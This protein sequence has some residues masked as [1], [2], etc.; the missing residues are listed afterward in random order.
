MDAGSLGHDEAGGLQTQLVSSHWYR[1]AG[2]APR[3]RQQ[4]RIHAQ[5]YRGQLW[6][7]IEDRVNGRYHRFERRAWRIIR[8]LDG[9]LTLERLWQRLATEG[10]P[11]APSQEDVLALLGQLHA[12]DLLA[13]GSLPDLAEAARRQRRLARMRWW[14]RYLNPLALRISLVDPDR[15]LR[16]AVGTLKPILNGFGAALWLAWVAPAVVLAISHWP[17]LTS[18]FTERMLAFGNLALLWLIFPLVKALHEIGHG[19]ACKM[20][21]GEVHDMGVMMLI[22]LPV[23]YVD[24]SSAWTFGAKRDRV[25]VGAAGMLV[26]LCI[27]AG[28]FYAWLWLEPGTARAIA[29]D[30]AVLASVTTVVFN[31]NPLLR[32]DGYYIASDVLEIPN[33]GQRAARYWGYLV[34][35][36]ILRH[37]EPSSPVMARGEA[38]WFALYAPLSLGYRLLVLFSIGLFVSTKYFAFGVLIAL[39]SIGAALGVPLY[40]GLRG[41]HRMLAEEQT[42]A[43]G[44][45][46]LLG[47]FCAIAAFLFVVPLRHSTQVQGVVWLPESGVVRAEN[48]GFIRRVHL[49][50]GTR[51]PSGADILSLDDPALAAHVA[52]QT[53]RVDEAQARYDAGTVADPALGEQLASELRWQQAQ[54]RALEERAARL[55]VRSAGAGR[56]WIQDSEDLPGRY[57]KEGEVV[58]YVIPHAAPRIRVIVGQADADFIRAHTLGIGVKLPFDP[59]TTW[60]AR[61]VR[62]VPEASNELPSAALGREGGGT[63]ATD[64]RDET[65]RKA[66]TSHFEYELA[67]PQ[68]FPYRL[69]GSRASVRFE[70]PPEPIGYRIWRGLRR[71]FLAYFRS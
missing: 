43:G 36:W 59:G 16:R 35:R 45:L 58:G 28:A 37:R 31:A 32:Y 48:S 1:A 39:W 47:A 42:G 69:I 24:A 21:G 3:L 23:P 54:L 44:K 65:G 34:E 20:R 4:L 71:L 12:L 18:N 19:V 51:V 49:Q 15:F 29:Y 55:E 53:A 38:V 40:R 6:F 63:V 7:V 25:L 70:H 56:L 41:L 61:I 33:L 5:R 60:S 57:V 50:N 10:G 2:I 66:L 64:P 11:D 26:E 9:S 22:F 17:E 62:A 30:T 46:A 52:E 8:L 67:L 68:G 13:S 14:Q 27:A